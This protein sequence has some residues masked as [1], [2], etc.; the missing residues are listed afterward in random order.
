M[1]LITGSGAVTLMDIQ[2]RLGPDDKISALIEQMNK[3]NEI[4]QDIRFME[5]NLPTGHRTTVRTGLP[6]ATWRLLNYGVQP[7]KSTTKQVT[8]SCGMLEAYGE[9][10]KALADLNGNAP[11]FRLSEDSAHLEAMNQAL[12]TALFYGNTEVDPEKFV[13]FAPRFDTPSATETEAGYNMIDGGAVDGQTDTLSMWLVVW[14][15]TTVHGIYP[16]GSKAGFQMQDLGEVTLTDAAGG[17]YQGYRTH[18]K[19]DVGLTVRDWRYVSRICNIDKSLLLSESGCTDLI[20]A[21]IKAEERIPNL[22][23]G[24]PVWYCN[25]TVKTMLRMQILAK[26]AYNITQENVSGK[27]VV[28]FDGIPVRRS[29]ALVDETAILD[30][31]GTFGSP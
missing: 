26:A 9:V 11:A 19:W 3:S 4:L 13:G 17:R 14:G 6:T 16:K 30:A 24:T 10:D 7:S 31:A 12:A 21:M 18:Y 5:G 22:Q 1:A 2:R 15:D 29:D 25:R 8:D 20:K 23:A 27:P 28:M